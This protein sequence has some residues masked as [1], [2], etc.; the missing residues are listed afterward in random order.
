V[1][2]SGRLQVTQGEVV[3]TELTRGAVLGELGLLTGAVRS[4]SVSAVRDSRLVHLTQ[5]QFAG[6]ATL[7]VM[8]SLARGLATRLQEIAPPPVS[9]TRGADVVVAVVALDDGAPVDACSQALVAHLRTHLRVAVPGQVDREGLE[10]A[11]RDADRVVLTADGRDAAWRDLCL[12]V[13]DRVVVVSGGPSPSA[14]ALPTRARGADLLLTGPPATRA[15]RA[16][17]EALLTPRS[18]HVVSGDVAGGTRA[19]AARLAG[20]SLGLVLAGGG[21]RAFAHLGVLDELESAGIVVDRFAGASVGACVAGLAATGADAAEV[22]AQI[23]EHFVRAN[24]L[25]RFTLPTKGLVSGRQTVAE[26]ERGIGDVLVEELPHEFRC[27]SVDLLNRKEVVHRSGRVAHVVAC[28]L[29]LPGLFPPFPYGGTLHVDGGVLNNLPVSALSRD[30]GPLVAVSISFGGSGR[31]PGAP[32]RTG[33]PRVPALGDTL[34]RT[35]MLASGSAA[36]QAIAGADLV[37]RPQAVG[38]GLLEFHQI[39]RMREAGREAARAALPQLSALVF[40]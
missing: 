14:D 29:R 8:T 12:R 35:M 16:Q 3:L 21:A 22:D 40:R 10:R 25:G 37:L 28:S 11:E 30:E 34:M 9:R 24:P 33:P 26:L 27:V 20:R 32:E 15:Q 36:E 2:R 23:Y 7:D 4:A 19:L 5:E 31:P 17:W 38:V 39:D 18:T 6:F 1:L 13:A